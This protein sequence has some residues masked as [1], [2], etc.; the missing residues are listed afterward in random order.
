[1]TFARGKDLIHKLIGTPSGGAVQQFL[2]AA[3][4]S[5]HRQRSRIRIVTHQVHTAD[6]SDRVAG[7]I[8]EY[9]H[10]KLRRAYTVTLSPEWKARIPGFR[11]KMEKFHLSR[12]VIVAGG[13]NDDDAWAAPARLALQIEPYERHI[14][15][16][17]IHDVVNFLAAELT[18]GELRGAV[19]KCNEYLN[20]L[21][22]RG[23]PEYIATYRAVVRGWL[24]S[25]STTG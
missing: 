11:D 15:V 23:R 14:A 1:M 24:T 5:V 21:N 6:S 9:A 17:D 3:L 22:L 25:S 2:I 12:Y 19:N 8:E 18:P 4:L 13:V 7:D 20:D 16:I 10:R